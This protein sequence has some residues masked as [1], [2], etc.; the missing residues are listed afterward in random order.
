MKKKATEEKNQKPIEEIFCCCHCTTGVNRCGPPPQERSC[1]KERAIM[2]DVLNIWE[3]TQGKGSLV[4]FFF[5]MMQGEKKQEIFQ[6]E[7][8]S[9]R[10]LNEIRH[11]KST[12]VKP[13]TVAAFVKILK[14]FISPGRVV[15]AAAA[16]AEA[17]TLQIPY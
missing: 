6:Y 13:T 1:S 5:Q 3:S 10:V 8:S 2:I 7:P 12:P 4:L 15:G 16:G 11:M 17:K 14:F 9:L